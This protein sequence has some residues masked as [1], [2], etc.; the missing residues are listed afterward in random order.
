[1]T[2]NIGIG[3]ERRLSDRTILLIEP[4]YQHQISNTGLGVSKDKIYT[5]SF[6]TGL[7]VNLS[8]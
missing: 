5:L 6:N 4:M 2:A 8:K 7:K 1:M 3:L